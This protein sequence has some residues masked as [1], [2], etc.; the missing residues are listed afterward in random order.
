[1]AGILRRSNVTKTCTVF[2]IVFSQFN[3]FGGRPA[4]IIYS[5]NPEGTLCAIS[6]DCSRLRFF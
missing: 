5:W 3:T 4:A 1:M 6:T 2:A